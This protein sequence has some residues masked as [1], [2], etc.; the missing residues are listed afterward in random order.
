MHDKMSINCKS[1]QSQLKLVYLHVRKVVPDRLNSVRIKWMKFTHVIII[2][3]I[4]ARSGIFHSLL[5]ARCFAIDVM[6]NK[7]RNIINDTYYIIICLWYES[8]E[9]DYEFWVFTDLVN[10]RMKLKQFFTISEREAATTYT[11]NAHGLTRNDGAHTFCS[12]HKIS[13]SHVIVSLR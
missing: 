8:N 6:N 11:Q 12:K 13:K 2:D 10:N 4:M 3:W 7:S 9:N 1:E 5:L